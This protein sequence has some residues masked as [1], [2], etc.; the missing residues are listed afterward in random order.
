MQTESDD[1]LVSMFARMLR[2]QHPV[3]YARAR[4]TLDEP[5]HAAMWTGLAEGGWLDI[6]NA[7][8]DEGDSAQALGIGETLGRTLLTLPLGFCAYVL[9]PLGEAVPEL[10]ASGTV[11][12]LDQFPASGRIGTGTNDGRFVDYYGRRVQYYR[13][14]PCDADRAR[15]VIQRYDGGDVEVVDGLDACVALGRLPDT[16]PAAQRVFS[17]PPAR[18]R[19]VLRR[20]LAL[21][22]A[23]MLGAASASLDMAIAYAQERRQF[24]RLIGQYQAIKHPLANAWVA[25]DN[26]RYAI[27]QLLTEAAADGATGS[28]IEQ[29][30]NRLV[31]A[32]ATQATRLTIQ[33]HG[34]IG[35]A[36]EHDAHLFLKRVYRIAMRTRTLAAML[37][38]AGARCYEPASYEP[39]L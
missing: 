31:T 13:V 37:G 10:A 1:M 33:V 5:A 6:G 28:G 38:G 23:E 36:W 27:R 11:L 15:W 16:A 18:M 34:G 3:S 21:G 30:A 8:V 12:P 19:A 17:V 14:A 39:A 25:L 4:H 26:G 24:G 29:T 9:G 7:G 22:L 2:E 20:A 35:F 32:A